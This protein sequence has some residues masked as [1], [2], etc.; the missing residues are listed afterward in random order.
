LYRQGEIIKNRDILATIR[1][2]S[3]TLS[4]TTNPQQLLETTLDTLSGI[5]KTDCCWVH[6][7]KAGNDKLPLV[8]S[9]G[10]TQDMKRDLGRLD[11]KHRFSH[12]VI[13]LGHR[14]VIPS[15]NRDGK[16]NIPAFKKSGFRSLIAVPI[17]TYR[18]HGILGAAY[19]RK[20]KFSEDFTELLAVIANLLGM[21]LHKSRLHRQILPQKPTEPD[22][23]GES[24]PADKSPED[25]TAKDEPKK[26]K[27]I[28][29]G[30]IVKK[31][32]Q[33]GNFHD[34]NR[35]MKLFNESHK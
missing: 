35:S 32:A 14:I 30:A 31:K 11:S 2:V 10:F 15:L 12:E 9:L 26:C 4:L 1:E 18:V 19:R 22:D 27:N 5:L 20:T 29:P 25:R 21:S 3:E 17:M 23:R 7:V 24:K 28:P 16:Y 13:G 34:H 6:I 8:A 33:G